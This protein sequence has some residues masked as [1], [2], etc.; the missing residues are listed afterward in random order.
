M[1]KN[2]AV[3]QAEIRPEWIYNKRR[4]AA[5]GEKLNVQD[6]EGGKAFLLFIVLRKIIMSI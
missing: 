1:G 5:S 3:L 4:R 2:L 6:S